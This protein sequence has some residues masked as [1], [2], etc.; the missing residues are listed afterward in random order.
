MDPAP[1]GRTEDQNTA[2]RLLQ[3]MLEDGSPFVRKELVVT[4]QHVVNSF[5]NNFMSLMKAI[6]EEDESACAG[7][8]STMLGKAGSMTRVSSEDMLSEQMMK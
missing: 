4:M 2:N 7:T 8:S 5:P 3:K 1:E 6:A